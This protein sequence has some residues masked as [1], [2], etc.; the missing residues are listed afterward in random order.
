MCYCVDL[1]WF[2]N[3]IH[4]SLTFH[5]ILNLLKKTTEAI[6]F[7]FLA[8][9]KFSFINPLL[10]KMV[11]FNRRRKQKD[12]TQQKHFLM[13][14]VQ[15]IIQLNCFLNFL[16]LLQNLMQDFILLGICVYLCYD[17]LILWKGTYYL[18]LLFSIH[19]ALGAL[20]SF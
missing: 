7:W 12:G 6:L 9:F 14:A 13:I 18:L 20:T 16:Y 10:I 3:L 5:A 2:F 8:L 19:V 15:Q 4:N 1:Q 17:N 11:F